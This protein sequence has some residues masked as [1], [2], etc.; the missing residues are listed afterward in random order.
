MFKRACFLF[1]WAV[2]LPLAAQLSSALPA[3]RLAF[4]NQLAKRGLHA[5]ALKEYEAIREVKTLPRDE[6]RFRLGEA[7]RHV[8]RTA[9][10]LREFPPHNYDLTFLLKEMKPPDSTTWP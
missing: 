9:E 6:I 3:D 7:Y 8:G 5:E 2:V 4:A 10:A 1:A